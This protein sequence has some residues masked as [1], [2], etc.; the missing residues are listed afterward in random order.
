MTMSL[1]QRAVRRQLALSGIQDVAKL[2]QHQ[3]DR[4]HS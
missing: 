1:I 3:D 4:R 2:M